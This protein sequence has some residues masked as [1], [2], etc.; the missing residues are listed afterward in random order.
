MFTPIGSLHMP[1]RETE[2]DF[3]AAYGGEQPEE[4]R[5]D[6]STPRSEVSGAYASGDKDPHRERSPSRSVRTPDADRAHDENDVYNDI[7]FS[8]LVWR[9]ESKSKRVRIAIIPAERPITFSELIETNPGAVGTLIIRLHGANKEIKVIAGDP[10]G[11]VSSDPITGKDVP[12][13]LINS[14]VDSGIEQGIREGREQMKRELKADIQ[15][16]NLEIER[17]EARLDTALGRQKDAEQRAERLSMD[18]DRVQNEHRDHIRKLDK[19]LEE[20]R[21]RYREEMDKYREENLR[22]RETLMEMRHSRDD[23]GWFDD[24]IGHLGPELPKLIGMATQTFAANSQKQLA[25]GAARPQLAASNPRAGKEGR[26]ESGPRLTNDYRERIKQQRREKMRSITGGGAT[27]DGAARDAMPPAENKYAPSAREQMSSIRSQGQSSISKMFEAAPIES[28]SNPSTSSS[29]PVARES[30]SGEST[31]RENGS[32]DA[33][34]EDVEHLQLDTE[35][36]DTEPMQAVPDWLYE[37]NAEAGQIPAHLRDGFK[38]QILSDMLIDATDVLAENCNLEWW[39]RK[40]DQHTNAID[41]ISDAHRIELQDWCRLAIEIAEVEGYEPDRVAEVVEPCVSEAFG[42]FWR[43][44]FAAASNDA[45]T[46]KLFDL[47]R[48][49]PTDALAARVDTVITALRSL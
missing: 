42:G 27:G 33:G 36:D 8:G 35:S 37:E 1:N 29:P 3:A 20:D 15:D 23:G 9:E 28:G 14:W 13:S 26:G 32:L 18:L 30:T 7:P 17:L 21:A 46:A 24:L 45:L 19:S 2:T 41:Q 39:S 22:I 11:S 4:I 49:E 25:A 38:E 5:S 12:R 10:E 6:S 48:R 34:S 47:A 44:G 40:V 43:V 31:I 16:K